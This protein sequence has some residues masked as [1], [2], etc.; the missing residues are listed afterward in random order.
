MQLRKLY[1][2]TVTDSGSGL[3]ERGWM[4][5]RKAKQ[6]IKVGETYCFTILWMEREMGYFFKYDL[7]G[8][9]IKDTS[10]SIKDKRIPD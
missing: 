9:I 2:G 8:F 10:I 1:V 5:Q 4:G 6:D 3:M 7:A